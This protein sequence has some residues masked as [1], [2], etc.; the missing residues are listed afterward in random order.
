MSSQQTLSESVYNAVLDK[1]VRREFPEAGRLPS[2]ASLA[3]VF[4]VSRPIVREALAR[5]RDDGIIASRKG[6]GSYVQSR[7]GGTKVELAP[8]GSIAQ[9]LKLHE[10]RADVEAA[11]A[12]SAAENSND[13]ACKSLKRG[14]PA[15]AIRDR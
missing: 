9:V 3:E 8:I 15:S 13:G 11:A 6:S 10:F 2:E 1:I 5:L 14:T 4:G 12:A 7:K